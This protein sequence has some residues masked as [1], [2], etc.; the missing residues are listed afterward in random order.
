MIKSDF[1]RFN[2]FSL[3]LAKSLKILYRAIFQLATNLNNC[4]N[5]RIYSTTPVPVQEPLELMVAAGD[6]FYDQYVVYPH[7]INHIT[8]R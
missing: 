4:K 3:I 2:Q 6:Y 5:A 7:P 1:V 8:V